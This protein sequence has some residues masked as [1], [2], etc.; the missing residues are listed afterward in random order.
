MAVVNL[1]G[2]V[3]DDK[4]IL[5]DKF[6]EPPFTILDSKSGSWKNRKL[7]W[8]SLGIKSE[9]GRESPCI[10]M[11]TQNVKNNKVDYVS[12][13]DPVLCEL[14]YNWFC[15]SGGNILD[16]FCGGSVRGI[17]ACYLGFKYTGID[18]RQEQ[19]DSNNEQANTI[20]KDNKPVYLVGDSNK[21]L[22]TLNGSFDFIFSCP[23]YFNL[24]QYSDLKEDLSNMDYN[25]FLSAYES[26]I[27]KS[28][29]LLK[30][31]CYACFVVGEV[32]DENG[33][34]VGLVPDTINLFKKCGMKYYNEAVLSTPIASASMRA[35]NNMKN[36]KLTKVHQNILIFKKA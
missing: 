36:K 34:Y 19:I 32:R 23:P 4:N 10:H 9:I 28:C 18:L 16:P 35:E 21:V 33:F 1:F 7:N 27:R 8:K 13:F 6:L 3:I 5:R 20:L 22:D 29:N 14:M 26:I 15:P 12:I 30:K 25:N 11:D 24:E 2:K 17:V 31:D